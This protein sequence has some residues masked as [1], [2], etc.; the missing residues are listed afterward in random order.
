MS[1][2]FSQ[3]ERKSISL[4]VVNLPAEAA[5]ANSTN[6]SVGDLRVKLLA[7]DNDIK[8]FYDH[9]TAQIGSYQN[10]RTYI[11]GL[12][13]AIVL[14]SQI[15]DSAKR[16]AGN[17]YLPL[18]GAW[19]NFTPMVGSPSNLN[20]QPTS[21]V[22][23]YEL[24]TLDLVLEDGG[25]EAF[26][27][28]MKNGQAGAA[29][30]TMVG[31]YAPGQ[32]SISM[33]LGGQANGSLIFITSGSNSALLRITSYTAPD[34][35]HMPL[36][37]PG[38]LGVSAIIE[39][40]G[41]ISGII[42]NNLPAHNNTQRNTFTSSLPA[43]YLPMLSTKIIARITDWKTYLNNQLFQLNANDD[44]RSPQATEIA[45]AITSATNA[46]NVINTWISDPLTGTLGND[47][48]YTDSIFGTI[49]TQRTARNSFA[50][51]R[52]SQIGTALG[53][54]NQNP[55]DGTFSGTG[56]YKLRY[57]QLNN[58][59]N[60]T[61]GPL[62]QYWQQGLAQTALQSISDTKNSQLNTFTAS[63]KAVLLALSSKGT[64]KLEVTST[65]DFSPGQ[66]VYVVSE[67]QTELTGT[68][69]TID[70]LTQ[71]TL[72]FV[73]PSTYTTADKARVLRIVP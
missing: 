65:A 43:T 62:S 10:E 17:L 67:T 13:Y 30:D 72:N 53:V 63:M 33:T 18:N 6:A 32:T 16:A 31:S 14:E 25:F 50:P 20:G 37:A 3:A 8:K 66:T 59:I 28:L 64:Q 70:N 4:E 56:V 51:T 40:A 11:D 9:Y 5:A 1:L 46:V 24:R 26:F 48:K 39:S 19:N 29:N 36:P 47:S 71:M 58:R 38:I 68:I 27:L 57:D 7:R 22:S 42:Y 35:L 54:V 69:A 34:P 45:A 21:S 12:V 23:D 52:I 55:S 41:S 2:S 73:V 44:P 60:L 49:E 61:G 15:Q